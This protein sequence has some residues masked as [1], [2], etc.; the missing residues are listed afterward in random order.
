MKPYYEHKGIWK[1]IKGF[2]HYIIS[3]DGRVFNTRRSKFKKPLP[4]RKGYL[5]I[6]LI[7]KSFGITKKIHR[8]VAEA[9]LENF[10]HKLQ[11]NHKNCIKHDNR[12]ENLEMVT[13]SQNTLHAWKHGK[14]KL[15]KKGPNGRFVKPQENRPN[16]I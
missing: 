1:S 11:V 4:D 8:L 12:V 6:R 10:S 14:M 13:Q 9:F 2:E 15:T 16:Q 3:N 7:N 5:R